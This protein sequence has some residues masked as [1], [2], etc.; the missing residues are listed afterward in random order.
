[1]EIER[2]KS[3][4]R[5]LTSKLKSKAIYSL[6]QTIYGIYKH[7]RQSTRKTDAVFLQNLKLVIH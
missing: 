4:I 5:K 3:S 7:I 2:V 6:F 1:M